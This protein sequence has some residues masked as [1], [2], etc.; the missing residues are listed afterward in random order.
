MTNKQAAYAI[1]ND[2]SATVA[3]RRGALMMI[4]GWCQASDDLETIQTW[5]ENENG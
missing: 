4:A 3:E 1:L 5:G 2:E